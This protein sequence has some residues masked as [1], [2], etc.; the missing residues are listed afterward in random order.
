MSVFPRTLSALVATWIVKE[1]YVVEYGRIMGGAGHEVTVFST[2]RD[3]KNIP[4]LSLPNRL[5]DLAER[6]AEAPAG[7]F[8]VFVA[9]EDGEVLG[10]SFLLVAT[11][12]GLWHD[13]L[14]CL[15]GDARETSTWV[16]TQHRGLGVRSSLLSK[17]ADYCRDERLRFIA[18][19]ERGNV[20]SLKSSMK[21]GAVV[22]SRNV[23]VKFARRNVLS[24]TTKPV[25]VYVLAGPRR[26]HR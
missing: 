9:I 22:L 25:R 26:S 17:Q 20:N 1:R 10:Y 12:K 5:A 13:S 11:G 19:I 4:E 15:V 21:S 14:P 23:L 6:R 3:L 18:V 2:P 16:E 24:V 7:Q 8:P